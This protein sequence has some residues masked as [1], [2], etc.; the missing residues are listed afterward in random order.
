[1][2][3]AIVLTL[4]AVCGVLAL[5][6]QNAHT[7][8]VRVY[9]HST[10]VTENVDVQVL[11]DGEVL[12]T[13]KDVE[14]GK[15]YWNEDWYKIHFSLFDDSKLITIRAV[16]TGGLLGSQ[17]DSEQIIVLNGEEYSVNLYV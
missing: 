4:L 9:V 15:Y 3:V 17:E 16:S 10:H 12:K 13:F 6:E 5:A 7:A 14:P 11:I 8:Y 2:A 1:M